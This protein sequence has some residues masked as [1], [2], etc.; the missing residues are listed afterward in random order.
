M[1]EEAPA[2]A[3]KLAPAAVWR[4][5]RVSGVV[6]WSRDDMRDGF[7]HLST[8]AQ[9]LES[10]RRHFA[11]ADDLVALE[12]ALADIADR[13]RFEMAPKRGEAF[14]HLYGELPARLVRRA[15]RMT[16][17]PD[18]AFVFADGGAP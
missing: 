8:R 15:L 13:V 2:F 6:A 11:G 17:R 12:I 1:H 7:M 9:L 16:R 14:P 18:G 4:E 3:Y 5:A 10:A